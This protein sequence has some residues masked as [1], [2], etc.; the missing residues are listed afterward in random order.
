MAS[1]AH[2]LTEEILNSNEAISKSY[3][4]YRKTKE[5]LDRTHI[6]LGRNI[7]YNSANAAADSGTVISNGC[8]STTH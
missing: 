5:I 1:N 6:A 4:V 8:S 2:P 3:D 7:T